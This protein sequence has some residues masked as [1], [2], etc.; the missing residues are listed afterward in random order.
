[1]ANT[2]KPG[3]AIETLREW[4]SQERTSCD[5]IVVDQARVDMFAHATEDRY[6]LHTDPAGHM[7]GS[8]D[9]RAPGSTTAGAARLRSIPASPKCA[10]NAVPRASGR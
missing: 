8:P 3:D 2:D 1:V 6:W 10:P 4:A 9:P 5:W 7:P